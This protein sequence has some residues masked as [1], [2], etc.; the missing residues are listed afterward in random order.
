MGSRHNEETSAIALRAVAYGRTDE[1]LDYL[2]QSVTLKKGSEHLAR[3]KAEFILVP[4]LLRGLY[5]I[6]AASLTPGWPDFETGW[7][8]PDNAD[9]QGVTWEELNGSLP[10]LVK[11]TAPYWTPDGRAVL[12]LPVLR[13]DGSTGRVVMTPR[14]MRD[15]HRRF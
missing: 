5:L 14:P 12:E 13:D 7:F 1:L 3:P 4:V 6:L 8:D 11:E 10:R 2:R 15:V 9:R